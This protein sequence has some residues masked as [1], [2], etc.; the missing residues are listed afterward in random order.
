M[1][2]LRPLTVEERLELERKLK[3]TGDAG[4]WKRIFAILG[5]DDGLT[6]EELAKL[7]RLSPWTI[8]EYL[9]KYSSKNKTGN[10][11]R[12][13]SSSKLNETEVSELE[14]HL[15]TTTYLKVKSIVA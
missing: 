13:G 11:P 10:D 15:S 12:G 9:K 3:K 4:D 7:T 6:I 5:Y 14:E 1:R 8:E 2:T